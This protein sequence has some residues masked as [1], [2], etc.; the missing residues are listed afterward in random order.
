MK[1][2]EHTRARLL[3]AAMKNMLAQGPGGLALDLVAREAG[4]SK[5]GLL[6]HF[7]SK[8]A[9]IE[10]LLRQLMVE[11]ETLVLRYYEIE[12]N[13]PGRWLR[14]YVR[15]SFDDQSHV[16]LELAAR[17]TESFFQSERLRRMVQED[18]A[19]W[20]QRLNSDGIPAVRA[21]VVRQA[22]DAQWSERLIVVQDPAQRQA[23]MHELLHWIDAP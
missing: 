10:A 21:T 17:L 14:S 18:T 2:A 22:A 3:D 6:H 1:Q 8:E 20:Q 12:S 23:V 19:H 13:R 15:A 5:G 7:P 9:L 16:P 4:I 11:F